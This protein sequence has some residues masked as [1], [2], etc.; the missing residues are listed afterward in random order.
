GR[1]TQPRPG[2]GRGPGS[3][4]FRESRIWRP[5]SAFRDAQLCLHLVR[6]GSEAQ[7]AFPLDARRP[8]RGDA[9][10]HTGAGA[11][12]RA[13]QP[14]PLDALTTAPRD[15]F[16]RIAREVVA[17]RRCPRLVSWREKSAKHP[18]RRFRGQTYW[19][20]PLP[21]FG[22]LEARIL[23]VGLAPA[24]HGGNRTGRL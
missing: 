9:G 11:A 19:A 8:H 21:A 3:Q 20:R 1:G 6:A 13:I 17:C 15:S 14:R 12:D 22:D 10:A 24:A 4:R 16:G 18:P 2:N 5:L 7:F 23:L